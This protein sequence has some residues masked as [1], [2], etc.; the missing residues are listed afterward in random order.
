[1]NEL[2]AKII[3]IGAHGGM[4]RWNR[5]EKVD[6]T[7]RGLFPLKAKRRAYTRGPDRRPILEMLMDTVRCAIEVQCSYDGE[8]HV[9]RSVSRRPARWPEPRASSECVSNLR[10]AIV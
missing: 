1:M 6:A 7:I 10:T 5:H 3:V 2:L 8:A 4:E 9:Q